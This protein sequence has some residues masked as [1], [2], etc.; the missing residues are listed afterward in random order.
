MRGSQIRL[1]NRKVIECPSEVNNKSEWGLFHGRTRVL[2][3]KTREEFRLCAVF[4][5][6]NGHVTG[7]RAA[8]HTRACARAR[9]KCLSLL[10]SSP[11]GFACSAAGPAHF[12]TRRTLRTAGPFTGLLGT[13][14]T[15]NHWRCTGLDGWLRRVGSTFEAQN[16]EGN[17]AKTGRKKATLDICLANN[18]SIL[19]GRLSAPRASDKLHAINKKQENNNW[20]DKFIP[21]KIRISSPRNGAQCFR[22]GTPQI[23]KLFIFCQ[24]HSMKTRFENVH[25]SD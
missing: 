23:Q 24:F 1:S 17:G 19:A 4:T 16:R 5:M 7:T 18:P 12:Y 11:V 14:Q 2:E 6:R 9:K 25:L 10:R 21:R 8:E 15:N 20:I 22:G 3:R 13:F